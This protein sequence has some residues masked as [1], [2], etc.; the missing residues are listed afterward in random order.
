M[1]REAGWPRVRRRNHAF[2]RPQVKGENRPFRRRTLQEKQAAVF[3]HDR[4]ADGQSKTSA[5]SLGREIRIENSCLQI[6]GNTGA[7]VGNGNLQVTA[8]RQNGISIVFDNHIPRPDPD[9]STRRHR[10]ARIEHESIYDLLDLAR[11]DFCLPEVDR[12]VEIRAQAG[13]IKSKL[14]GPLQQ[15]ADRHDLLEGRAPF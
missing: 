1:K 12:D 9:R 13:S 7:A 6:L 4:V 8:R 2:A 5:R 10:F 14:G 15:L 11:I 3:F